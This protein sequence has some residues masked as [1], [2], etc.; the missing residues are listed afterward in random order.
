M[1]SFLKKVGVKKSSH[2]NRFNE[3]E[4]ELRTRIIPES[5]FY[6]KKSKDFSKT[7]VVEETSLTT[8]PSFSV[9]HYLEEA[10][11]LIFTKFDEQVSTAY[12]QVSLDIANAILALPQSETERWNGE[13]LYIKEDR[14][15]ILIDK[16][17]I[18]ALLA[19]ENIDMTELACVSDSLLNHL[20]VY[21][22]SLWEDVTQSQY[23]S[24]VWHLMIA[25]QL[26]EAKAHLSIRK[27]FRY[28]ENL[29]NW[30]KQLNKLL[31]EQ[32]SG[33]EVGAELDA[34]FDEV[35]D[36][37]RSPYW[38]TDRQKEENRFPITMN[39]NYVRL[40]LAIIRW[41]YVEKQ[42]L[43]GHWNEVLAQVSR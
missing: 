18:E 25:G 9:R 14:P 6:Y 36:I 41:L 34:M 37:I 24:S 40:Q 26:Q 35:F 5:N 32:Q 30:T 3:W 39:P 16:L 1:F 13:D 33:A 15:S 43:K 2:D 22:G 29:Y 4:K 21:K 28:T 38:K 27:S 20:K 12:L 7:F 17:F 10:I 19:D 31:I 8:M 42:P 11:Y 23:L